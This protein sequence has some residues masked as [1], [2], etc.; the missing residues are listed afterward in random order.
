MPKRE[1]GPTALS[2]LVMARVR[3]ARDKRADKRAKVRKAK[4]KRVDVAATDV[5]AWVAPMASATR[6]VTCAVWIPTF[7]AHAGLSVLHCVQ[8]GWMQIPTR[9]MTG[10]VSSA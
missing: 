2:L 8:S 6:N 7:G 9:S 3:K 4:G 10:G 1:Q 5:A